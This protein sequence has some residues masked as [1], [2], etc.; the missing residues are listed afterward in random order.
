MRY[1]AVFFSI[2]V[3]LAGGS[4]HRARTVA[5]KQEQPWSHANS[6]DPNGWWQHWMVNTSSKPR[7]GVGSRLTFETIDGDSNSRQTSTYV[8]EAEKPEYG[9]S[10]KVDLVAADGSQRVP[11][12][13]PPR[14]RQ[15]S[16]GGVSARSEHWSTVTVPAGT[17]E[18][19][20]MWEP[21]GSGGETDVWLVPD[22]PLPVQR[23]SRP[24][25]K[26]LYDPPADG[27]VPAGTRLTRLVSIEST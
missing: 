3:L 22:V 7:Y 19:G 18:A 10:F 25:V 27:N 17:F 16:G 2:V 5:S 15:P 14:L 26:E 6:D 4:C 12:S 1:I 11:G 24:V 9:G 20:R 21:D 13:I 23:W 8:V